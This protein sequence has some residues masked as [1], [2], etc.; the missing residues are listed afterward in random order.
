MSKIFY[1]T[2]VKLGFLLETIH[3]RDMALHGFQRDFV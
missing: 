2:A 3:H 1:P